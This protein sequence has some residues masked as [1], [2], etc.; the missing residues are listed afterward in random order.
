[1][2]KLRVQTIS[3]DGKPVG[4]YEIVKNT[5]GKMMRRGL[6]FNNCIILAMNNTNYNQIFGCCIIQSYYIS[7]EQ[8]IL[9][10]PT[11]Y[12]KWVITLLPSCF[13]NLHL[14]IGITYLYMVIHQA[15]SP[16]FFLY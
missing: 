5:H 14:I 4:C 12:F 11:K 6:L 9:F 16:P 1:M 13:L 2:P 8:D 7:L 10:I 15:C 3:I